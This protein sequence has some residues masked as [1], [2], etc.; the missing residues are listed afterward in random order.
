MEIWVTMNLMSLINKKVFSY[1]CLPYN[2][3]HHTHQNKWTDLEREPK[4][5][6]DLKSILTSITEVRE[7]SLT[8]E[9]QIRDVREYY[10]TLRSYHII[11]S[12]RG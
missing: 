2:L 11:V 7:M 8:T 3:P 4:S 12:F 10:D 9:Q 6:D 1:P 5:L